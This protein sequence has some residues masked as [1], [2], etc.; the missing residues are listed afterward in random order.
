[1]AKLNLESLGCEATALTS[2]PSPWM[3]LA[4]KNLFN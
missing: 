3:A 4:N 2:E 1:M